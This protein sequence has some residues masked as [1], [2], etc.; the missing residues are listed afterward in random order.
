M[1]QARPAAYRTV[2]EGFVASDILAAASRVVVTDD[3]RL[4][5]A[6][7]VRSGAGVADF[8]PHLATSGDGGR[9]WEE[10]RVIWPHLVGVASISCALSRSRAGDLYL[11][12]TST[13]IDEPGESWWDGTRQAMKQNE[14]LWAQLR[15]RRPHLDASRRSSRCPFRAGP[16]RPGR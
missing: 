9:T 12:G 7:M 2:R 14:L 11:Y 16:R 8:V 3:G 10:R 6:Y 1:T 15:R 5:C 4:I 13:P